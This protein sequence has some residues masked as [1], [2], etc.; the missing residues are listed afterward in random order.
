[1]SRAWLREALYW[2]W[3]AQGRVG[4]TVPFSRHERMTVV[5]PAFHPRRSRNIAPLVRAS[6]RCACVDRVVI[7]NHNPD[8][9]LADVLPRDPRLQLI[10]AGERRGCGH[11]WNV[12]RDLPGEYFLVVDDDQLLSSRQITAL[13]S[14]LLAD[15]AVPHGLCG[16]QTGGRQFERSEREVDVL[17]NVY[18]VTRRHV[19]AFHALAAELIARGVAPR[20]LEYRCDDLVISRCGPGRARIHDAGFVLRCRTG[21]AEGVAIFKEAGFH[22]IR[23]QVEQ[24][25]ASLRA[26]EA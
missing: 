6:L 24:A 15:P 5:V 13:F 16:G 17:Y 20:D 7:S 1:M 25:I 11:V 3:R 8:T 14:W 2:T 10:E 18:A 26:N 19:A 22:E 21:A 23:A 12:I 4:G 9:R